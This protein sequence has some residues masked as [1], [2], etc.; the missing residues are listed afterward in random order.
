MEKAGIIL[1]GMAVSTGVGA[2]ALVAGNLI[3]W[4]AITATLGSILAFMGFALIVVALAT[5]QPAD[6][7]GEAVEAANHA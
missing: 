4:G 5:R 7:S 6:A 2:F 1:G 3:L